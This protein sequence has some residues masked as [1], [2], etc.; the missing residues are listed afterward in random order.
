MT[1]KTILLTGFEPFGDRMV[2][3]SWEVVQQLHGLH[4]ADG[5]RVVTIQV[6]VVWRTVAQHIQDALVRYQPVLV[7]N[8]GEADD[9]VLRLERCAHNINGM[10]RDNEGG[11]PHAECV[12]AQGPQVYTTALDI[13]RILERLTSEQIVARESHSAGDY[14]CNFASYSVY[15][16]VARLNPA[17]PVLFVHVPALDDTAPGY[18]HALGTM[19]RA[20]RLIIET[21]SQQTLLSPHRTM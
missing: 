16:Y 5:R 15:H 4:L 9:D 6:P 1:N 7:V 8:V 14:L 10:L 11:L 18:A 3:T 19:V 2:N 13:E 17:P 12:V 20:L 21:A